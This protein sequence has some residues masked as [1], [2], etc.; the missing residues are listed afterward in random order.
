M[1]TP[2]VYILTNRPNGVLYIGVTSN[3]VPSKYP[4]PFPRH[5]PV[6]PA[7]HTRHS[8][9]N[10]NLDPRQMKTPCVYILANKTNGVLYIGVTSNVVPS[11]YTRHSREHGNLDA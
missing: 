10:G 6:V 9:E 7:P 4:R 2:S 5:T 11:K 3:V 8:R 1:K